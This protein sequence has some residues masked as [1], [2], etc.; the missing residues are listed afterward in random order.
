MV[1]P[2]QV[3]YQPDYIKRVVAEAKAQ[4]EGT[5]QLMTQRIASS[6][7]A[8]TSQASQ[9]ADDQFNTDVRTCCMPYCRPWW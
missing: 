2:W 8:S 6:S 1:V 7:E 9:D 3:P 5:A 4:E